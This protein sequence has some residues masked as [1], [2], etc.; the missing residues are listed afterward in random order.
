MAQLNLEKV[1]VLNTATQCKIQSNFVERSK[2]DREDEKRNIKR[3]IKIFRIKNVI[4]WLSVKRES[5]HTQTFHY[6]LHSVCSSFP[7]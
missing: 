3:F 6:L 1:Y 5:M 4:S 2:K 7:L